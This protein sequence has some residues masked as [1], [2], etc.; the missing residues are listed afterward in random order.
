[1]TDV[2]GYPSDIE[3]FQISCVFFLL[4]FSEVKALG[5]ILVCYMMILSI[6][7]GFEKS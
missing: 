4:L 6:L 1:M 7:S 5:T 2:W 3:S